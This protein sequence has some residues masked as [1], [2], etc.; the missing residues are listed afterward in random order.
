M[1]KPAFLILISAI[2]LFSTV[3]PQVS[4]ELHHHINSMLT[5]EI[6]IAHLA[7]FGI[8]HGIQYSSYI[9]F[10]QFHAKHVIVVPLPHIGWQMQPFARCAGL[11]FGTKTKIMSLTYKNHVDAGGNG[12]ILS[13]AVIGL[14]TGNNIQMVSTY[15]I[16]T[17]VAKQQFTQQQ[18]EKCNHFLFIRSCWTETV[19]IPRGFFHHELD[20]IVQEAE[21][22]AAI[23]MRQSLGHGS[24]ASSKIELSTL[25]G[26]FVHEHMELRKL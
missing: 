11:Y 8:V 19:N 7:D 21:R 14:R 25:G 16:V 22:R 1:G 18:Y 17:V 10:S 20:A 3:K 26:G 24:I 5:G 13:N 2:I 15:G 12:V 4:V 23:A 9:D 6:N